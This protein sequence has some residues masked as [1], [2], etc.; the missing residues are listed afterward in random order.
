VDF[1]EW[2][3][4]T[5]HEID[6]RYAGAVTHWETDLR[7]PPAFVERDEAMAERVLQALRAICDAH[8]G[9][10]VLVVTSGGPIRAAQAH[11]HGI[12]QA[13]MAR[14]LVRTV[15]NCGLVEL[16]VRGCVFEEPETFSSRPAGDSA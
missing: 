13:M 4:L 5:R 3:G 14:R 10:R 11:V 8:P 1:G 6:D 9:G 2:E 7:P 12:D 15:R 16:V